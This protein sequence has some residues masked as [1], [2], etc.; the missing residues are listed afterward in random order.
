MSYV[1]PDGPVPCEFA[2]VGEAPASEEVRE[3][4]G[5][6]GPSGALLWPLMGGLAKLRRSDC[7]VTNLCKTPLDNDLDGDDKLSPAEFDDWKTK[8]IDELEHVK[9][10]RILAVG[11]LAAKALLGDRYTNMTACNGIGFSFQYQRS[12]NWALVVPTWHPAA[13]LRGAHGE[14]DSLAFTAS[15]IENLRAPQPHPGPP[16]F[17]P[18]AELT[19]TP[20]VN[21]I[22]FTI[23]APRVWVPRMGANNLMRRGAWGIDTEGTPDDPICMTVSNGNVRWYVEPDDVAEWFALLGDEATLVFHNAPWDWPVLWAAGAPEDIAERWAWRDTMELAYLKQTCPQGLKDLSWRHLG[24][25]MTP[26][27]DLVM[28]YQTEMAQA[29]AVGLIAAQTTFVDKRVGKTTGFE[30]HSK[31]GVPYKKPK[32]N[33][34]YTIEQK[35]VLAPEVKPLH[36]ALGNPKLL[37]ERLGPLAPELSLRLVPEKARVEYATLDAWATV[38]L[39]PVLEGRL[40]A[41]LTGPG[42][43]L[44][45]AMMIEALRMRHA[46]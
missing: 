40:T 30:T 14:K 10:K 12:V 16:W 29:I 27:E 38:K 35:A 46:K 8:L 39:L 41:N 19:Q 5:F 24:L 15:A 4:R 21:P 20:V 31:K 44:T 11:A 37:L 18:Y 1:H 36:R 34:V 9:P 25:H 26:F 43:T 32:P 28:P 7:Y 42:Q 2:V 6:V 33:R 13:A 22:G 3:G 23:P 45:E 17:S